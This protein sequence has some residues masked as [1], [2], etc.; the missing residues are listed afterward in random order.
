MSTMRCP[1]HG[2]PVALAVISLGC[3]GTTESAALGQLANGIIG[4]EPSPAE[5]DAVVLLNRLPDGFCTG[6]LVSPTLVLTARH[7]MFDYVVHQDERFCAEEGGTRAVVGRHPLEDWWVQTGRSKPLDTA[8]YVVDVHSDEWLDTCAMDLALVELDRPLDV[9][10]LALRLDAPPLVGEWGTLVGWGLTSTNVNQE[11]FPDDRQRRQIRV[12]AV[13]PGIYAPT[14][15]TPRP[16]DPNS[17]VGTEG[18]CDGDSGGPLIADETGAIIGIQYAVRPAILETE[19]APLDSC[20]GGV[21]AFQRLDLQQD[22]IRDTFRRV[23]AAP[24]VENR[25]KP[26]AAGALCSDADECLSGICVAAGAS[27]FCAVYCD[28]GQCPDG[29]ECI[30]RGTEPDICTPH[31]VEFLESSDGP[32]CALRSGNGRHWALGVTLLAM[33][34]ARRGRIRCEPRSSPNALP[35]GSWRPLARMRRTGQQ[36]PSRHGEVAA[37]H[38]TLVAPLATPPSSPAS[39]VEAWSATARVTR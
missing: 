19:P 16:L 22:W 10:P 34:R 37:R 17:F 7:C 26:A 35:G 30:A 39:H 20:V 8:A 18:A 31:D 27:Q 28:N 12:E 36:R 33:L 2:A 1:Q 6:S 13:S 5:Q 24:W 4:G 15:W 9:Q 23:G 3:S 38:S 21:S 14:G 29:F 32:S 11:V 25:A